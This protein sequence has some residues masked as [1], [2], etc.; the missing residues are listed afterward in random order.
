MI[1]S[2]VIS[3]K[4]ILLSF[5]ISLN[6]FFYNCSSLV[7]T[8][9]SD[10][11]SNRIV[12]IKN[13]NGSIVRFTHKYQKSTLKALPI[14]ISTGLI[15]GEKNQ[16][17]EIEFRVYNKT[18]LINYEFIEMY[19]VNGDKWEWFVKK[20]NKVFIKKRNYTIESYT[21][22]IDSKVDELEKFFQHQPIYLKYDSNSKNF[23]RLENKHVKSLIR[24]LNFAQ[25]DF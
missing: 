11:R 14:I 12:K 20:G 21:E 3:R 2:L 9:S 8:N 18:N 10:E 16:F 1:S 5:S 17:T 6:F 23:K 25:N 22:R 24:I 4:I 13:K 7:N 15:K 19:N